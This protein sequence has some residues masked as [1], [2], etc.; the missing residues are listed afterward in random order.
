MTQFLSLK[1]LHLLISLIVVIPAAL[2]YGL[3]PEESLPL[4]FDFKVDT[5]DLKNV[6]RAIMCLYLAFAVVWLM[7]ALKPE[8]WKTATVLNIIFMAGLGIG[9]TISLLI[10]GVPSAP[11]AYGLIGELTLAIFGLVQLRKYGVS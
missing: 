6:F 2:L 11:F 7:G 10:D 9:R 8:Y 1:N 4:L 3:N 5:T